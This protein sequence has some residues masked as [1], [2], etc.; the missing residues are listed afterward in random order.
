[1]SK[2]FVHRY[3]N[4]E[5]RKETVTSRTELTPS[6]A[7]TMLLNTQMQKEYLI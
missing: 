6:R 2:L 5:H 3:D 1:M 7:K 4:G